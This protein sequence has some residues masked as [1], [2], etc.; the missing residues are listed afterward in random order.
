MAVAAAL[1]VTAA[2]APAESPDAPYVRKV[3]EE[4]ARKDDFFRTGADSPVKAADHGTFLPL[5]YFDVA[6][7]YAP[8][9]RLQLLEERTP[10]VRSLNGTNSRDTRSVPASANAVSFCVV[11][12]K[13]NSR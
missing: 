2:C 6:P 11:P 8:P 9:A 13:V 5:T 7:A 10:L 12:F 4:R 1:V 3:G